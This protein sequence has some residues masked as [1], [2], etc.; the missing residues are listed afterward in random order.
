MFLPS[1]YIIP[2][3]VLI[4][5]EI[6]KMLIEAARTGHWH[7]AAFRPGGMPSTHSAFV[8]SVLVIVLNREP[9]G[10]SAALIAAALAAVVWYDAMTLRHCV[11][12][13]AEVLNHIQRWHKLRERVGHS[14]LEVLSGI[15]WGSALTTLLVWLVAVV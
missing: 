10:S 14:G 5:T 3:V 6:L 7:L 4:L 1:S 8:T 11:G 9:W 15:V 12:E 2:V 13:Q